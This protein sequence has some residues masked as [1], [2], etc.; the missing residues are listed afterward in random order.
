MIVKFIVCD[1]NVKDFSLFKLTFPDALAVNECAILK[2]WHD[3]TFNEIV[4]HMVSDSAFIWNVSTHCEFKSNHG[5]MRKNK[6]C[7]VFKTV[8]SDEVLISSTRGLQT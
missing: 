7:G 6:W 4:H 5:M 3:F 1:L 2:V 8:F